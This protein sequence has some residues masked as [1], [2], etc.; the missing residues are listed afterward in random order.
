MTTIFKFETSSPDTARRIMELFST[1]SVAATVTTPVALADAGAQAPQVPAAPVPV[2]APAA[3]SA[4]SAPPAPPAPPRLVASAAPAPAAPP[5][6]PIPVAPAVPTPPPAPIG[7]AAPGAP[8]APPVPSAPVPSAPPA[9]PVAQ[10]AD[11]GLTLD[12]VLAEMS[13]AIQRGIGVP[14]VRAVNQ[15]LCGSPRA[16]DLKPEHF[17]SAVQQYRALA[18]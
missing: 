17:A 9:P 3:P 4:P 12:Q 7:T 15:G 14:A 1:S 10:T 18:A 16:Q 5:A 6:P 13:A 11:A 8:P 2:A